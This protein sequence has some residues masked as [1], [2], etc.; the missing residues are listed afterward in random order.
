MAIF[1][2]K[3]N[4][5]DY[6]I[7]LHNT[8]NTIQLIIQKKYNMKLLLTIFFSF[9]FL[10]LNAQ[11]TFI[12]DTQSSFTGVNEG[13]MEFA[14]VDGDGDQDLFIIGYSA[15]FEPNAKLYLN[16]GEGIFTLA[17][18]DIPGLGYA[19]SA[20]ADV[21]GDNDM[22][23][24]IAGQSNSI[25]GTFLYLNDGDGNFTA[26]NESFVSVIFPSIG[27]A[28]VDN[29][30]DLDLFISGLK[31]ILNGAETKLYINDGLGGFSSSSSSFNLAFQGGFDFADVDGDDDLDILVTGTSPGSN[32]DP[33]STLYEN[34]GN[35]NFSEYPDSSFPGVYIS[36]VNFA[37]IDN[38]GDEDVLITGFSSGNGFSNFLYK[39]DGSGNFTLIQ[40]TG[41]VKIILGACSFTDVDLDGDLDLFMA[42]RKGSIPNETAKLY[43]N[44]GNGNF[45]ESFSSTFI[46]ATASSLDFA[47]VDGDNDLDLFIMGL[48]P[49]E[50]IYSKLYI[51]DLMVVNEN[52]PLSFNAKI[53]PN[54]FSDFIFLNL[55]KNISE[56]TLEISNSDGQVFW[57]KKYQNCSQIEIPTSSFPSG[58]YYLKT[59]YE[60]GQINTISVVKN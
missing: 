10:F 20:F 53:Y 46:G 26:S 25:T 39:N 30:N 31:P 15:D 54:P 57:I 50:N 24:L 29:D 7:S 58:I 11:T 8:G 59:I 21:D 2:F 51:N 6:C 35:G 28:D 9:S 45:T 33:I 37:D 36:T 40:N 16:N 38:D 13:K 23:L 3:R 42:G 19:S 48:A 41:L 17:N 22:D 52:S 49:D 4:N 43:L 1:V 55:D 27:F 18:T 47:D 14:D 32:I 56:I 12:E 60:D 5:F 34:D 44:D